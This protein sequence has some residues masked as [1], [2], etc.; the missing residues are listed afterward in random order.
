MN[1]SP[2]EPG[3]GLELQLLGPIAF[4]AGGQTV[5]LP[6]SKKARAL[7]GYLAVT[8]RPQRRDRLCEL[9]W[10]VADDPRGA[11]RWTLSRLRSALPRETPVV[12][13]DREN[14]WLHGDVVTIDAR[15]LAALAGT[16]L[17]DLSTDAL[18]RYAELYRGELLE[19]LDLPDFLDF[20]AWCTAH[21]EDLRR[22]YCEVLGELAGRFPEEPARAVPFARRL[23]AVDAF[24]VRSHL[25]LLEL[26]LTEGFEE[27]AARRFAHAERQFREVSAPD[28]DTLEREWHALRARARS[29]GL[30][31]AGT[32]PPPVAAPELPGGASPFVGREQTIATVRSVIDSARAAGSRQAILVTGEPGAGKSRL[33]ERL[34]SEAVHEG[35]EVIAARAFDI[36][37]GRSFGPW[38]DALGIDPDELVTISASGGRQVLFDMLR[39]RVQEAGRERSGVLLVLDDIQWLDRDSA[40]VLH[41]LLRTYEGPIVVL[42]MARGGE[43]LDNAAAVQVVRALR[44]DGRLEE[45]ELEALSRDD[46]A[47]LVRDEPGVDPDRILAASAGNPLYALELVRGLREEPA[48]SS[49]TLVQL[50]RDRV[51]RLPDSAIDALRWAAVL[52]HSFDVSRLESVMALPQEELVDALERLERHALLRIDLTRTEGRYAFGH[53][54]IREAVYGELS[55]P[56]RRL[57]HRRVAQMLDARGTDSATAYEIAHHAELAGEVSL[58]VRACIDAGQY[59]VRTCA[60]S[61][62]ESLARRGLHLAERLDES[63]RVA[64]SLQLLH[65]LYSARTPDREEASARVRALAERALDLGLT[66]PARIGFQ[67]LSYLRWESS[68]TRDAHANI[69][70]AERVSRS[71]DPEERS[72]ALASA[73]RCL[74]L[75]ERNLGQAE[76]FA[77]EAS[78]VARR[79]GRASAAVSF[80]LGML[81]NHRGDILAAEEAF[82]EAQYLARTSGERLAEFGALEHLVM[83]ELDRGC[84]DEAA[85]Q[86][87][88]LVE[89]G[90]KV[91]PGAEVRVARA[92]EALARLRLGDG[93]EAE[94]DAA[95]AALREADAKYELAFVLTRRA[96]DALAAGDLAAAEA[97][98]TDAVDVARAIG[99]RSEQVIASIVLADLAHRRGQP[100]DCERHL[101]VYS[102]SS[103]GDLSATARRAA[104]QFL[105]RRG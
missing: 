12:E 102:S 97:V 50:L 71:A 42:L 23:A 82:R 103:A 88:A 63:E 53:D 34:R 51:A 84:A 59:A 29:V 31:A 24:N 33:G 45:I 2:T 9:F 57:M 105:D 93:D 56:R 90:G 44:R 81:A 3:A 95:V 64:S 62:A 96:L 92:L 61:D 48:G 52:G 85:E 28:S 72:Q 27:E 101:E 58:G 36:E 104:E 91:R 38:V 99:R 21:R 15:E 20:N 68:S 5:A 8:G 40:E 78:G 22:L 89:L 100:D 17:A 66:V 60:N 7:L 41:H 86:A 30:R 37:R 18:E 98:A 13:A 76:A 10:D 74:V 35:F 83:L 11:L 43:L 4:V 6:R 55:H 54:V 26:L 47:V 80:A 14:V 16:S 19:G 65:V 69:L 75:L 25:A 67:M 49:T 32:I 39:S 77:M 1:E 87:S 73:A 79:N 70:Q 46:I 94:L